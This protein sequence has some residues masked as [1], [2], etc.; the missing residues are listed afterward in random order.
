MLAQP[1]VSLA[2]LR[3][4]IIRLR[5]WEYSATRCIRI[6]RSSSKAKRAHPPLLPR[7]D[8]PAKRSKL[9]S[10]MRQQAYSRTVPRPILPISG[11]PPTAH[12]LQP[13]IFPPLPLTIPLISLNFLIAW[14]TN[15]RNKA[16][17]AE[18]LYLYAIF[19][20]RSTEETC[21]Y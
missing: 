12:N 13:T 5:E 6:L 21:L 7:S 9:Y 10:A 17:N 8:T 19:R 4:S 20:K 15:T 16:E 18:K 11:L 3:G 14:S 2:S 1:G